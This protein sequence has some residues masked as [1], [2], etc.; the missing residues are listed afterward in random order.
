MRI[1][2]AFPTGPGNRAVG[3]SRTKPKRTTPGPAVPKEQSTHLSFASQQSRALDHHPR[4]SKTLPARV[5]I[6]PTHRYLHVDNRRGRRADTD[7][8][9][10][11]M[12]S[13]GHF[14]RPALAPLLEAI[15]LD[16][17]YVKAEGDYLYY[18]RNGEAGSR[19][20]PAGWIRREPVRPSSPGAR[21]GSAAPARRQGSHQRAGVVP[22][23]GRHGS[24]RSCA[25][26]S[27]TTS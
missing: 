25:G 5:H 23:T 6:S 4:G 18:R 1:A 3:R 7:L 15:G 12:N 26:A 19:P 27:A 11:E 9:S 24:P 16:A 2:A 14:C 10:D 8:V 13:Y 22:R 17:T 20:R 21:R